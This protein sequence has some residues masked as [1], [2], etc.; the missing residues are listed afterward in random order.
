[1]IVLSVLFFAIGLVLLLGG[2]WLVSLDGS[3]YYVVAGVALIAVAGL[4]T[5]RSKVANFLYALFL[6]GTLVWSIMES[7]LSW[8]PLATRMGLFL[9]LAVPL[10]LIAYFKH[11]GGS[12]FLFPVWL[13]TA[14][15]TLSPLLMA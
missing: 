6:I 14:L 9:V 8:W 12:R 15:V 11:R 1:M 5:K 4:L 3:F 7:G 10:I 2:G 13:A